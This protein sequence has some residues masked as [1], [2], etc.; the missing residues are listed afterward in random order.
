MLYDDPSAF[1]Q[2]VAVITRRDDPRARLRGWV[3]RLIG[4]STR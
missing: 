2:A 3:R 1:W 4:A